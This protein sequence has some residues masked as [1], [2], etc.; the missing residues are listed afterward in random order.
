MALNLQAIMRA[1]GG[2]CIP[3]RAASLVLADGV[4]DIDTLVVAGNPEYAMLVTGSTHA[5]RRRLEDGH[6]TDHALLNAV[7]VTD[8]TSL[9]T[10]HLL[11]RHGMTAIIG[12]SLAGEALHA[13][14]RMLVA[15]ERAASERLAGAGMM[16]LTQIAR[17]GGVAAVIVELAHRIDGW[18]V[19][20]DAQGSLIASAGAGKLHISDA[21]AVAL[22]RAVRVRNQRLQVHQV[23]SDQDLAGYLVLATRS[24]S[25]DRSRDLATQ[26]AA[27]FDLLVRTHDPS[28]TERLGRK[29]LFDRLLSGG[30]GARETLRMWGV[31]ES[32]LTGFAFGTRTR[33]VDLERALRRWFDELGAE[34]V[35]TSEPG[36]VRGVIRHDLSI[37]LEARVTEFA[38]LGGR[39]VALGIGTP[40][41]PEALRLSVIQAQEALDTALEH[42]T[43]ILR[44]SQLPSVEFVLN[45]LTGSPYDQLV[46]VL[47]PLTNE[48]GDHGE[49]TRTLR[50]FLIEHGAQRRSAERLGIHRQTLRS[51][52]TRIE[53]LTGLRLNQADDRATAWI[54]LR[55]LER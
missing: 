2:V 40:A 25:P 23:G 46:G 32:R 26:A 47:S 21:V 4:A 34:H 31:H 7:F 6:L 29:A 54:A 45:G 16:L 39:Q 51:R 55:A 27:L 15:E 10:R 48:S 18:A 28:R 17:R 22:G 33:T 19:L 37:E 8:D 42:G 35:F 20:L 52:L 43:R 11:E 50:V 14:L 13:T 44:Y 1:T 36:R 41:P 49:L 24:S 5:L 30:D 3:A 9:T 53:Q 12:A 38:P